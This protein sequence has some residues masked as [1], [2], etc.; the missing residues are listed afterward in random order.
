MRLFN[1]LFATRRW[2]KFGLAIGGALA[3]AAFGVVLTRVGKV[4]AG[5]EP[6]TVGEYAWNAAVFAVI[7]GVVSP[8]VTWSA[9][10]RAPLWRTIVEPLGYA[11]AGG[12]AVVV[13]G[14]PWLLLVLPPVGLT[15]GFVRLARRYAESPAMVARQLSPSSDER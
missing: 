14:V 4:V 9:L 11:V 12:A 7:A 13:I 3:G 5:A 10:R 6:A 15:F 2:L 1:P 8:I